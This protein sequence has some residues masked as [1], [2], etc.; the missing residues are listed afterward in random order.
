VNARH[1][2]V[3]NRPLDGFKGK[4]TTSTWAKLVK[5]THDTALRD[6][7]PLVERGVL[8]RNPGGGRSTSY[9]LAQIS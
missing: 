4:L 8:V 2:L 7:Q 5:Y 9:A 6:I 3:L 1:R